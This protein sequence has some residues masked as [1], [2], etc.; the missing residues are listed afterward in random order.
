M[1]VATSSRD[2]ESRRLSTSASRVEVAPILTKSSK[3]IDPSPESFVDLSKAITLWS[4][5]ALALRDMILSYCPWSPTKTSLSS[6]LFTI[7]SAC[8]AVLVE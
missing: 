2:A 1:R 7:Y 4:C 5:G 6:E 3:Y 8:L